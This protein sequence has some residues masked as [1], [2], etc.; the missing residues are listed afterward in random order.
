MAASLNDILEI[1]RRID[2]LEEMIRVMSR[3]RKLAKIEDKSVSRM[4]EAPRSVISMINPNFESEFDLE[5]HD[6]KQQV[7]CKYG[8]YYIQYFKSNHL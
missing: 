3:S 6:F 7:A 5:L 1:H 8:E 4:I 2:R